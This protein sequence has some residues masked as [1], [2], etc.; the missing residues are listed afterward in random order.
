[1]IND[2][3]DFPIK[4]QFKKINLILGT[5]VICWSRYCNNRKKQQYHGQRFPECHTGKACIFPLLVFPATE[6][7][8]NKKWSRSLFPEPSS[9]PSWAP[10]DVSKCW[11]E[12]GQ[13]FRS[14]GRPKENLVSFLVQEM[15]TMHGCWL[16]SLSPPPCPGNSNP[17]FMLSHRAV[18]QAEKG[19]MLGL[20]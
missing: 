15:S 10:A 1:M 18:L 5:A 6:I 20:L 3:F 14:S 11:I 9:L 7:K 2:I 4:Q 16:K 12:S 19:T 17:N 13:L 8:K